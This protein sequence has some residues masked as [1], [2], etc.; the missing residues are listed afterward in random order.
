MATINE[1]CGQENGYSRSI[2]L[3][4]KLIPIGKTADNLKQFL[5]KDQERADAYPEIKNL[6]D[7]IHR[8]FIE[9]TLTKFSFVWEPL[10][11]D[12]ELYQNEKDK[13]KKATKKKALE[14]FQSG[15]RKKIVEAFKILSKI[16]DKSYFG[17]VILKSKV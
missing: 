6:I 3:R 5:E 15:A 9:D 17:F 12:F 4:N 2:T 16:L 14:K 10:F 7:E 8:G 1:F 11:D 13:S